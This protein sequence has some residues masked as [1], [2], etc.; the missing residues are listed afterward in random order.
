MNGKTVK[1]LAVGEGHGFVYGRVY[2]FTHVSL[3]AYRTEI[4]GAERILHIPG[5]KW[6]IKTEYFRG[7]SGFLRLTADQAS[8][9]EAEVTPLP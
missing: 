6:F 3:N 7:V 4:D 2:T 8:V 5:D 1:V 9:L